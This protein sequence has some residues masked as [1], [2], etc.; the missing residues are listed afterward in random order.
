MQRFYTTRFRL[1][2][3]FRMR[4]DAT[5]RQVS[6]AVDRCPRPLHRRGWIR[7]SGIV[8]H[9]GILRKLEEP[10]AT[11]FDT[12]LDCVTSNFK[13]IRRMLGTAARSDC[14]NYAANKCTHRRRLGIL[15]M[16]RGEGDFVIDAACFVIS[17][18][19]MPC[20]ASL[21]HGGFG[22]APNAAALLKHQLRRAASFP[23]KEGIVP[24]A[25]SEGCAHVLPEPDHGRWAG[26]RICA[27][28]L[29]EPDHGR[30][31]GRRVCAADYYPTWVPRCPPENVGGA[32][33]RA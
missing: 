24:A 1:L 12:Y 21:P 5:S 15:R 6:D 22:L 7:S 17:W 19:T 27:H 3:A 4:L 14:A 13:W 8:E 10:R 2:L 16:P 31:A 30:W 32:A 26:R 29:P 23:R 9:E 18:P 20:V 33:P 11:F 28:V 25:S